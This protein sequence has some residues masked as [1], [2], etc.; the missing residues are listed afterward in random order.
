MLSVHLRRE[1]H[2]YDAEGHNTP[3]IVEEP[4]SK[5]PGGRTYNVGSRLYMAQGFDGYEA[6]KSGKFLIDEEN[7]RIMSDI[8]RTF[9]LGQYVL[10]FGG[11]CFTNP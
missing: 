1:H 2:E 8:V 4:V 3:S 5:K 9:L 11:R 7:G 10:G 6:L